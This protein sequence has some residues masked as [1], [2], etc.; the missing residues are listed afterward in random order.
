[1]HDDYCYISYLVYIYGYQFLW[2]I[3][4]FI[5]ASFILYFSMTCVCIYICKYTSDT[6]GEPPS[7]TSGLWTPLS[8]GIFP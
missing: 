3:H 1:M 7:A 6:Q 8:I 5:Y 4:I 2:H